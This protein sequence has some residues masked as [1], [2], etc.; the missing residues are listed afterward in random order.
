[1]ITLLILRFL[2]QVYPFLS[3]YCIYEISWKVLYRLESVS[4]ICGLLVY[5]LS[6]KLSLTMVTLPEVGLEKL[7]IDSLGCSTPRKSLVKGKRYMRG[8]DVKPE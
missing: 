2:T 7:V 6:F 5:E 1:M 4:R 8:F 3:F